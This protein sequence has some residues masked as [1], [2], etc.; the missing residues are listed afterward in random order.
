VVVGGHAV[1]FHGYPRYTGDIDFLVR[2]TVENASRIV[3]ALAAFGFSDAHEIK[4][5]LTQPEKIVQL[6]RPPNRID[7]LTSAS[8]VDFEDVWERAI[9]AEIDGLPVRFPDLGSLLKNKRAS[10]RTKDLADVEEPPEDGKARMTSGYS[11]HENHRADPS[12]L[13]G[14]KSDEIPKQ[15]RIAKSC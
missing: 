7:I 14:Q 15:L 4:A 8:G 6:G 11:R 12:G 5:S 3:A 13:E 2:P 1:A 9:V 10:G